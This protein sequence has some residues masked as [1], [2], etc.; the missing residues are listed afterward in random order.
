MDSRSVKILEFDFILGE[1]KS[2]CIGPEGEALIESQDF[3]TERDLLD[4]M[5]E[6]VDYLKRLIE[7]DNPV[8]GFDLPGIASV[9]ERVRKEGASIEGMEI[10]AVARFIEGSS[11]LNTYASKAIDDRSVSPLAEECAAAPLLTE[12]SRF[13]FASIEEDGTVKETLPPLRAIRKK[14]RNTQICG[15]KYRVY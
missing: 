13:V 2:L 12:V 15:E 8:P 6:R 14:M 9:L 1:L 10:A 5:L 3:L 4:P 11:A 7:S